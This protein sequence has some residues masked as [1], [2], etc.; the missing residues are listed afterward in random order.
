M[1]VYNTVKDESEAVKLLEKAGIEPIIV[2]GELMALQIDGLRI[3][4]TK[5]GSMQVWT[6]EKAKSIK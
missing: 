5:G 3:R 1:P 6:Q 4:S 2:D